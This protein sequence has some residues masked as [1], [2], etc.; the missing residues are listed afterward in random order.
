MMTL[1][2]AARVLNLPAGTTTRV[3]ILSRDLTL[4]SSHWGGTRSYVC[5]GTPCPWCG[6]RPR[7]TMAGAFVRRPKTRDPR[8]L[9]MTYETWMT[10][11]MDHP[12]NDLRGVV[13][14]VHARPL[15]WQTKLL[16]TAATGDIAE[17]TH[18]AINTIARLHRLP[19]VNDGVG[20]EEAADLLLSAAR[21][22]LQEVAA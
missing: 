12:Q 21:R 20:H 4:W 15:A 14:S 1:S 10:G 7:K 5:P 17:E 6:A 11:L 16:G 13:I 18:A 22:A 8:W 9:P 3:Q 2:A 19:T